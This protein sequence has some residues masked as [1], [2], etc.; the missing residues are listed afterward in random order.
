MI[1][2]KTE[3]TSA[4]KLEWKCIKHEDSLYFRKEYIE[5]PSFNAALHLSVRDDSNGIET[6][7]SG[8][9]VYEI[10][11]DEE[12]KFF[13][14]YYKESKSENAVLHVQCPDG[15]TGFLDVG[16][17]PFAEYKHLETID[18]DEK[19]REVYSVEDS[20]FVRTKEIYM[21]PSENSEVIYEIQSSGSYIEA[22]AKVIAMTDDGEW[23]KVALEDASAEG[24][25]LNLDGNLSKEMGGPR[26][27]TP[28]VRME[29]WIFNYSDYL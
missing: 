3:T 7:K 29:W 20:L 17:N 14:V 18:I 8:K 6:Y 28:Y 23:V 21:L 13:E 19:K 25:I 1:A 10:K 16:F 26:L 24:W 12:I 27:W 4:A 22:K 2:E 5:N 15:T 9:N 11:P